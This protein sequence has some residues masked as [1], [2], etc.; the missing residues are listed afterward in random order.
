MQQLLSC[1][2]LQGLEAPVGSI[3]AWPK[4]FIALSWSACSFIRQCPMYM[5]GRAV[6]GMQGLG[7]PVGS[8]VAGLKPLTVL[9]H[10]LCC[11]S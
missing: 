2:G 11:L 9:V 1:R 7:R 4:P 6:I 10:R 3:V 5:E 8:R